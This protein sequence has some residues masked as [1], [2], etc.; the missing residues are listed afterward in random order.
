[1]RK[2]LLLI[3]GGLVALLIIIAGVSTL[4]AQLQKQHEKKIATTFIQDTLAG[5]S[6]ASYS[7]FSDLAQKSQSQD[8]W[9]DIVK[10]LSS[11]FKNE[12]PQFQSLSAISKTQVVADYTITGSDG[13]Y[14]MSVTL[15]K[16][17]AGWQVL[18]FASRLQTN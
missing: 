9:G 3:G 18:T 15:T 10:K 2:L 17:K 13:K 4:T 16:A 1:M 7:A 6:Q 14:T 5:N 12:Q 8:V 11:F